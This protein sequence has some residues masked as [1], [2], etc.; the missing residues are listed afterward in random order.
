MIIH[1]HLQ[2]ESSKIHAKITKDIESNTSIVSCDSYDDINNKE[3]YEFD[4]LFIKLIVSFLIH[5][6]E[7]EQDL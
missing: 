7:S 5:N 1:V 6:M 3:S 4:F 2:D